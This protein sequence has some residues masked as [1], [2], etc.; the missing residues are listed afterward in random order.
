MK[1]DI[2]DIFDSL[3]DTSVEIN[4]VC[5]VSPDRIIEMTKKKIEEDTEMLP[6]KKFHISMLAAAVITALSCTAF[7]TYQFLAPN[8]I[9]ER[10][11]DHKLADALENMEERFDLEPQTSG[12]YTFE[13]L[14]IASGK[15]LSRFTEAEKDK[16]YVVGMVTKT[17][18][19]RL[20]EDFP[21]VMLTPLVSGYLPW[22]VNAFTLDGGRSEFI[23]DD[24]MADYFIFECNNIEPFADKTIY[25][26]MYEIS[27]E[28]GMAPNNGIFTVNPDGSIRFNDGFTKAHALFEI[29]IDKSKADPKAIDELLDL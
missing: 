26:A 14:G 2:R 29:P 6:K 16:S 12:E 5:N 9:A 19:S 22:E 4:E 25:M 11:E 1:R 18:G 10:F 21:G 23:S 28:F 27:D 3:T 17:D 7:A 13:I 20:G 15:G 24:E 8:E